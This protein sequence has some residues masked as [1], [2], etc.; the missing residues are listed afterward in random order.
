MEQSPQFRLHWGKDSGAEVLEALGKLGP[1]QLLQGRVQ[2]KSIQLSDAQYW[3][4]Q[5]DMGFWNSGSSCRFLGVLIFISYRGG[6]NTIS[7]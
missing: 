1:Y 6:K 5:L 7:Y 2:L 4:L 3:G